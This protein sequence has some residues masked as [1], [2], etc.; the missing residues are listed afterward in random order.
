M[1]GTNEETHTRTPGQPQPLTASR[2]K[3][4]AP[5]RKKEYTYLV[6]WCIITYLLSYRGKYRSNT[7]QPR[8]ILIALSPPLNGGIFG[9]SVP[10]G[11]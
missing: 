5:R 2:K 4:K 10:A 7:H 1:N 9:A 3:T 11:R 8:V 6:W